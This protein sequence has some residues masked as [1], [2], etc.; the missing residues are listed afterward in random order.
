MIWVIKWLTVGETRFAASS[1]YFCFSLTLNTE[2]WTKS[3]LFFLFFIYN[4]KHN[5]DPQVTIF[6]IN[7]FIWYIL[8]FTSKGIKTDQI[9]KI[10]LKKNKFPLFL[11]DNYIGIVCGPVWMLPS[12]FSP[13]CSD[14]RNVTQQAP[15][16]LRKNRTTYAAHNKK[17]KIRD[18]PSW[19]SLCV[20]HPGDDLRHSQSF[21]DEAINCGDCPTKCHI[22]IRIQLFKFPLFWWIKV[23][24]RVW[25]SLFI[26]I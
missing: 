3:F 15:S 11:V 5:P 7:V 6:L 4:T 21:P 18:E 25:Q 23:Q 9:I 19:M 17:K 13:N 12:A 26:F 22:P 8:A 14:T 20:C 1:L 24:I 10:S 2:H 16:W